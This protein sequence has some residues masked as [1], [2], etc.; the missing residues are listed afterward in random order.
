MKSVSYVIP[1]LVATF[2]SSLYVQALPRHQ[3]GVGDGGGQGIVC[4][5]D[6][7]QVLSAELLDIVEAKYFYLLP[8]SKDNSLSYIE[9]TKKYADILDASIP[10]AD[11]SSRSTVQRGTEAPKISYDL[12]VGALPLK[13]G[14]YAFIKEGALRIDAK[15]FLIPGSDFSIPP[16]WDSNP[17][18]LPSKKGC[19]L[20]QI[21]LYTDGDNDV[22]FIEDVWNKL[23]NVNK[24]ALLIHESLYKI[25]RFSGEVYSDRT[26]K[27][28]GYL[29]SGMKFDWILRDMP[30][31]YL[32]CWT[33]D[34]AASFRFIVYP[35]GNRAEALFIRYD[36]E[37]MLT[38]TVGTLDLSPFAK[39]YGLSASGSNTT[40]FR[41]LDNRLLEKPNYA[42]STIVN[43]SGEVTASIA[44]NNGNGQGQALPIQC[45]QSLSSISYGDDGSVT[46]RQ[47]L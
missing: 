41:K 3:G 25:Q 22:R 37:V 5:D 44:A 32:S 30:Q 46:V 38:R 35:K 33:T 40:V 20:E 47:G 36:N 13:K 15:K 23:D 45:K 19:S 11:L 16:V 39:A 24:A 14:G 31:S 34:V 2:L 21:A 26:R 43:E 42:F 1:T 8:V 18:V 10:S 9:I 4:R 27:A 6:N 17:R 7:G 28:V 29:F 12:N